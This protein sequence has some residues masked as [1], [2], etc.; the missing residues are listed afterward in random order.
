MLVLE[1][2][3]F[4]SLLF[5]AIVVIVIVVIIV[6]D[7][8]VHFVRFDLRDGEGVF[9]SGVGICIKNVLPKN[10]HALRVLPAETRL[11]VYCWSQFRN[12]VLGRGQGPATIHEFRQN[13]I[14][15][16]IMYLSRCI[17]LKV[18]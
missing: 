11:T 1:S 16:K 7:V 14:L 10:K 8:G 18:H 3:I 2:R 17:S 4:V 12:I 15:P 13:L 9:W 5:V 6:F